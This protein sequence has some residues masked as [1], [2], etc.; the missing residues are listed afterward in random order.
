[1][2]SWFNPDQQA[3]KAGEVRTQLTKLASLLRAP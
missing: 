1:M 2:L 3:D